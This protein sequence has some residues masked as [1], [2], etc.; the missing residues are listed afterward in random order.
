MLPVC[1]AHSLWAAPENDQVVSLLG[2]VSQAES[3]ARVGICSSKGQAS[4]AN[5]MAMLWMVP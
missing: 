2:H 3:E 5:Q 4:S 1:T